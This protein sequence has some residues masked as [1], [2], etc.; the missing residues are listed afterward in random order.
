MVKG[1]VQRQ[2][3][4]V[5]NRED[6]CVILQSLQQCEW[7]SQHYPPYQRRVAVMPPPQVYRINS[8]TFSHP[9]LG[10]KLSFFDYIYP[11]RFNGVSIL[12]SSPIHNQILFLEP[13]V[14]QDQLGFWHVYGVEPVSQLLL[15]ALIVSWPYVQ[16]MNP[17]AVQLLPVNSSCGYWQSH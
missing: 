17:V 3:V 8:C 11:W 6:V 12:T 1:P 15:D 5:F 13:W 9:F 2:N 14:A 7:Y 10:E 16:F 4:S